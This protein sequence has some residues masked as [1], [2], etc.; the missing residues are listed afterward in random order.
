MRPG[1]VESLRRYPV[2]SMQGETLDGM[3]LDDRG[4]VGDRAFAVVDRA[5]GRVA[6]AKHPRK[7]GRLLEV[8]AAYTDDP[9]PDARLGTIA[10]ELPD[11]TVLPGD[12]PRVG[13]ALTRF[14]GRDVTLV[15]GPVA[16]PVAEMIWPDVDGAVPQPV[17]DRVR[18]SQAA[19]GEVRSD[20]PV[21][22]GSGR[23]VD[24]APVHVLPASTLREIARLEP[25]ASPHVLRFRPNVVIAAE[26]DGFVERDW[27]GA[28]LAL[29]RHVELHLTMPTV[30]C[31][32]TTLA[33]GDLPADRSVLQTL[34]RSNRID[35][36]QYGGPWA[37]AGFYASVTRGG[38]VS[39]GDACVITTPDATA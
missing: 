20:W 11:G 26:V 9:G 27:S 36:P 29:G 10:V 8:R 33:Q 16:E 14:L 37:C 17:I 1:V 5:D 34:A 21:G 3:V 12:S 31:V 35:V 28:R 38:P 18:G 30:R 4:I 24:T 32:M 39:T 22:A 15:A 13:D 2:K 6:S 25:G 7:W 23:Y 19:D